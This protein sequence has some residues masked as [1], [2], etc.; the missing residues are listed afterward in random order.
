[1]GAVAFQNDKAQSNIK[2]DQF[3]RQKT[4]T[5]GERSSLLDTSSCK[6]FH[7][8]VGTKSN[9]AKNGGYAHNHKITFFSILEFRHHKMILKPC[10]LVGETERI[11]H[12]P[13]MSHIKLFHFGFNVHRFV[14]LPLSI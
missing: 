5:I 1:M 6:Q 7:K 11:R 14:I 8:V 3:Q 12:F 13:M 10:V 4:L 9:M 2:N